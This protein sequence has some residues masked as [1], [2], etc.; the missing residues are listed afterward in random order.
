M[1]RRNRSKAHLR[2]TP[3]GRPARPRGRTARRNAGS[4][5]VPGRRRRSGRRN[6]WRRTG[7]AASRSRL[8]PGRACRQW[9]RRP[10]RTASYSGGN[11]V[12]KVVRI[13]RR[14]LGAV[15]RQHLHLAVAHVLQQVADAETADRDMAAEHGA[16]RLAARLIGHAL[17]VRAG[18]LLEAFHEQGQRMRLGGVAERA[19]PGLRQRDQERRAQARS[20]PSGAALRGLFFMRRRNRN[21]GAR[22]SRA[23][24]TGGRPRTALSRDQRKPAD[25]R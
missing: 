25:F 13:E 8:A 16:G 2:R 1:S 20:P 23:D 24:A 22:G 9:R 18:V 19:G 6:T 21:D 5:T 4:G 14:A 17:Q 15:D 7:E 11:T 12:G 3:P 10:P